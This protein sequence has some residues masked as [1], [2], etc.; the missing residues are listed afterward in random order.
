MKKHLGCMLVFVLVASV[1][2]LR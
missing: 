1:C 2:R